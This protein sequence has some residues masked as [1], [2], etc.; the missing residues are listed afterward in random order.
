MKVWSRQYKVQS[1]SNGHCHMVVGLAF[2]FDCA[3]RVES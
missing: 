3:Y 1:M 2:D